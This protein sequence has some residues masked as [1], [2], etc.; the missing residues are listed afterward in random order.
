MKPLVKSEFAESDNEFVKNYKKENP[1]EELWINDLYLVNVRRNI[2][3]EAIK[4]ENGNPILITHLSIKNKDRSAKMDWRNFQYIKNQLVGDECEGVEIYPAESRLVD[5]ANQF[6]IWCFQNPEMRFPFGF[7]DGRLVT[8]KKFF[9][10]TQRPFAYNRKP[11]DLKECEEKLE[12]IIK[13][14]LNKNTNEQQS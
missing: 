3:C 14:E 5:G 8:E 6:H 12:N 11:S 13:S 4:D 7:F 9:G 1:S 2:P 10:E